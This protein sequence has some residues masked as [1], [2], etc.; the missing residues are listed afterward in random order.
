MSDING[1]IYSDAYKVS[2]NANKDN[3]E[4]NGSYMVL[5]D[6]TGAYNITG[7]LPP[8]SGDELG[9]LIVRN[10]SGNTQ[11]LKQNDAASDAGNRIKTISGT[12]LLLLDNQAVRLAKIG[13]FFYVLGVI[14]L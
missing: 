8:I 4:I 10:A 13:N 11:T 6:S 12:D 1:N 14:N 9:Y 3:L 7:F 2:M 5:S